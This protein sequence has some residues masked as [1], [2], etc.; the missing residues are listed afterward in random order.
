LTKPREWAWSSW[1]ASS[2]LRRH[3]AT[4]WG[5]DSLISGVP[6]E[7]LA[8]ADFGWREGWEYQLP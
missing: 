6:L 2:A 5:L 1:A 7:D 3:M 8:A 4:R